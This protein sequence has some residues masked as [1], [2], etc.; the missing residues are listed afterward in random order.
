MTAWNNTTWIKKLINDEYYGKLGTNS[1]K[2]IGYREA[3][4]DLIERKKKTGFENCQDL[5]LEFENFLEKK[6]NG[7]TFRRHYDR[8]YDQLLSDLCQN[9][10]VS[11]LNLDR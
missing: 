1:T 3:Y 2:I 4:P 8:N 11:P 6:Y 5:I 10:T 9:L 7:F